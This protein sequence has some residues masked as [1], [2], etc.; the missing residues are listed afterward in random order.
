MVVTE[1][2]ENNRHKRDKLVYNDCITYPKE[3]KDMTHYRSWTQEEDS[4]IRKYYPSMG[5]KG[6]TEELRSR[7]YVRTQDA[8]KTRANYLKVRR[9]RS[10]IEHDN[11]WSEMEIAI[12]RE[13]FPT[14]GAEGTAKRLS[15]MGYDRTVG[16]I[17][18]R[19]SMLGVRFENTKRRMQKGGEK[20][21]RNICLDMKLDSDVI[22]RL[23]SVRNRSEYVRNLVRKDLAR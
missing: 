9:D 6:T 15:D 22:K 4:L 16:S 12:L 14:E 17:S 3:R 19:A 11:A 8:V 20:V 10:K 7:L 1:G 21:V 5:A 13:T 18:S 2:F 23:D